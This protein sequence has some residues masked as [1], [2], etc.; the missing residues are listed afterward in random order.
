M[1]TAAPHHLALI[2]AGALHLSAASRETKAALR[3]DFVRVAIDAIET[4]SALSPEFMEPALLCE[5]LIEEACHDD[6]HYGAALKAHFIETLNAPT[7]IFT[8]GRALIADLELAG[9]EF[10]LSHSGA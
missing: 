6:P 10:Q 7:G 3:A 9:A 1:T 5:C 2:L 4:A 8:N